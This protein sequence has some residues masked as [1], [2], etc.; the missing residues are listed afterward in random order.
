MTQDF[1]SKSPPLWG[2]RGEREGG[3]GSLPGA[4]DHAPEGNWSQKGKF[5]TSSNGAASWGPGKRSSTGGY[6]E[7]FMFKTEQGLIKCVENRE[8][9]TE[10]WTTSLLSVCSGRVTKVEK[11]ERVRGSESPANT[12][13]CTK[14]NAACRGGILESGKHPDAAA[15]I[16]GL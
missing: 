3:A 11:K 16:L 6:R 15:I 13:L 9:R 14:Q 10:R 8:R 4:K 5:Q 2:K 1:R 7:Y 12:G